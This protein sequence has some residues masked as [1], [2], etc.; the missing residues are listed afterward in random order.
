MKIKTR[1]TLWFT[2]LVITLILVSG[3]ISWIGMKKNL[4]EALLDDAKEKVKEVQSVINFLE[5]E[6]NT[7]DIFKIE[8]P[9]IFTYTLSDEGNSL[10]NGAFL[11]MANNKGIIF[12]TSPNMG[13]KKLPVLPV[14]KV[15]RM[16]LHLPKY[17]INVLYYCAPVFIKEK[18]VAT[19]QVALPMK[20][21]EAFLEQIIMFQ[22]LELFFAIVISIFMGQF[23]SRQALKPVT[24]IIND[25]ENIDVYQLLKRLDTSNLARDEIGKLAETFNNLL[26]R[27]YDSINIQNRFISDASHELRSPLTAIIGHAELLGK[28]G[29]ENPEILKKSTNVIIK[30][31][32]RLKRLVN[33]MLFLARSGMNNTFKTQTVNISELLKETVSTLHPL[34]PQI[35]LTVPE[36]KIFIPGDA[37]ALKRVF[38]NLIDNALKAIEN[39]G[40]VNII[41]SENREEITISIQDNGIG[42]SGEHLSHLFE[43]FYRA[44]SA[45]DRNKGGSGLG[46]S[47]VHE[48]I[49]LHG[50][51]IIVQSE[52]NIGTI[53]TVTLKQS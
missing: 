9:D 30:E 52:K 12:A 42:I 4:T 20:K 26:E 44:E 27:I 6:H 45:R 16:T 53:F 47:I 24:H 17:S 35:R 29:T 14:G 19:L 3:I 48:I 32:E 40:E 46:L 51:S 50:G 2:A 21:N 39:E 25:V 13:N 49:K 23:L 7:K 33:D 10:Y 38:I 31:S 34:H 36:K 1:L 43:R 37:D 15:F 28:R 11:Q 41:L 5:Q 18:Q 22:G 8:D